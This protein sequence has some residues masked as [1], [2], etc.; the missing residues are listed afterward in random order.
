MTLHV[1]AVQGRSTL[2]VWTIRDNAGGLLDSSSTQYRSMADAEA[3]GRA[4]I[5]ALEERRQECLRS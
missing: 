3:Q 5:A 4:R 1:I 2:W